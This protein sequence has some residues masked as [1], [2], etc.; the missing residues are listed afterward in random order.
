MRDSPREIHEGAS[1]IQDNPKL[2]VSWIRFPFP[3]RPSEDLGRWTGAIRPGLE[4]WVV[5]SANVVWVPIKLHY[6]T[7]LPRLVLSYVD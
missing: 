6:L 7:T 3:M 4:F 5:L 1:G 2:P